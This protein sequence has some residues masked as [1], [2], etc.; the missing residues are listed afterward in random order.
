MNYQWFYDKDLNELQ[1]TFKN[2]TTGTV[3]LSDLLGRTVTYHL[4][5]AHQVKLSCPN[6]AQGIYLLQVV[7]AKTQRIFLD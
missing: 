4:V 1:L 5:Q 7:G 3:R 2:P 6:T